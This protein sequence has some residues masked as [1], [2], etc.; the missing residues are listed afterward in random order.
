MECVEGQKLFSL[1]LVIV[2]CDVIPI[3]AIAM[4]FPSLAKNAPTRENYRGRPVLSGLGIVWFVWLVAVWIGNT[5]LDFFN[6]DIP[7]WMHVIMMAFPLLSGTCAFGLF[8]DWVVGKSPKGFK[9]H[10]RELSHGVLTTGMLKFIGIGLLSLFSAISICDPTEPWF[11]VRIICAGLTIALLANLMNLFD[12][13]PLRA[14]KMYLIFLIFCM[15]TLVLSKRISL[16]WLEILCMV[17]ACIGPLIATWHFDNIEIAML[18][19]AGANTM[20]ALV[21]FIF[22]ITLPIWLLIPLT[23][24]LLVVNLLSEKISFTKVIESIP[25]L[26]HLDY[27][28][29]PKWILKEIKDKNSDS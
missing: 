23:V 8:D 6:I 13:R 1:F 28:F 17:L 20:G 22:S 2:L 25:V 9:G 3:A 5:A 7:E 4:I 18:G 15:V 24:V 27:L 10:F 21:G 12:L 14:S 19:D 11:V 29:R 26:R 16:D